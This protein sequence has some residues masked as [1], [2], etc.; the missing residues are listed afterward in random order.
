MRFIQKQVPNRMKVSKKQDE[1]EGEKTSRQTDTEIYRQTDRHKDRQTD[2]RQPR[3]I[4]LHLS[5]F[6]TFKEELIFF[7]LIGSQ[8]L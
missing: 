2:I 3:K 6:V 5:L 7:Q 4:L 8:K 1:S